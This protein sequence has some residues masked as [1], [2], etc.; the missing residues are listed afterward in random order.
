MSRFA[1][2]QDARPVPAI[3]AARI[4]CD[5][6]RRTG[7]NPA[8]DDC[9]GA[10]LW[11]AGG[12]E[13][14]KPNVA[15]LGPLTLVGDL[16]LTDLSEL[17]GS[18]AAGL[19]ATPADLVLKAWDRWG[20]AALNHLN[21]VFAFAIHDQRSRKLVVVRDRLGVRPVVYATA[22]GR[23]VVGG[24]FS[25]VLAGFGQIP[26]HDPL[27]I[28]GFLTGDQPDAASTAWAGVQRLPAGHLMVV[29]NDGVPLVREW[30]RLTRSAPPRPSDGPE[31]I[32]AALA[33]ATAQACCDRP[34]STMLS[35]GLDSSSL[36][37]LSVTGSCAGSSRPA[38]SLRYRDPAADEG[39]HIDAVLEQS[40]GML[41]PVSLPGEAA[42]DDLFNLD[43]QL[44]WQDQPF[45]APGANRNLHLFR[46]T[47][48]LGCDAILDGHGGDEIIGGTFAD[49]AQM[50]SGRHWPRAVAQT[51]RFARFNG[52][53][54]TSE[55]AVLL[56]MNGRRGFGRLGRQVLKWQGAGA[57]P[58]QNPLDPQLAAVVRDARGG[59]HDRTDDRDADV[60]ENVRRHAAMIA[61]PLPVQALEIL[62]R[63]AQSE[64]VSAR[65]PFY[66]HRVAELTIWQRPEEKVAQGQARALLRN[67]MRGVLPEI[68]RLRNDKMNFIGGF[69]ARLRHDPEGRF[70][71]FQRDPG[72][73]AGLIN[74]D[75]LAADA[76][77]L[78][79][80]AAP[81]A[82]TAFRLWRAL[83][84]AT[85]LDRSAAA[86]RTRYPQPASASA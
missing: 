12:V 15:A 33:H 74:A 26:D 3:P 71:S 52:I 23:L 61:G 45:F 75:L 25:T 68:V 5:L 7:I 22:G 2:L 65:Y 73:L 48:A 27:W 9:G 14:P 81:D 64:R 16:G 77:F 51:V 54:V 50:A 29:G 31:A 30:Y 66:D 47:R 42:D 76:T 28:A 44:D 49:V 6:I 13:D 82:F 39:R 72:P 78:A 43:A 80:S 58:W 4:Q 85:W 46:A 8:V 57:A 79:N 55:I 53:P 70:A 63:A 41:Q 86:S 60:P 36:A 34:T 24:D 1:V 69:W 67:A 17:R 21:G 59:S 84:L 38:L 19:A 62:S 18:L 32:R 83:A 11:Q 20:E 56:A 35:G 40:G 10:R 37:L